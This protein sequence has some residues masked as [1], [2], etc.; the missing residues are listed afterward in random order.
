MH[1]IFQ[2]SILLKYGVCLLFFWSGDM[3]TAVSCCQ[4][5]SR[6]YTVEI[7][8][9]ASISSLRYCLQW[10]CNFSGPFYLLYFLSSLFVSILQSFISLLLQVTF[11]F[12]FEFRSFSSCACPLSSCH[13]LTSAVTYI[14][15]KLFQV[16]TL[17]CVIINYRRGCDPV[18]TAEGR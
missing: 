16:L 10:G 7:P 17:F 3:N 6:L 8:Y 14:R 15:K 1:Q 12:L 5:Q 9:M 4:P 18:R 13:I 11:P 2:Q